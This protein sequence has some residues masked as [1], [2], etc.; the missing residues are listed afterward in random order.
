MRRIQGPSTRFTRANYIQMVR[1]EG[2][3]HRCDVG[4]TAF[5][6]CVRGRGGGR[7]RW[8][9]QCRRTSA[10]PQC[11]LS[12]IFPK[13]AIGEGL[14]ST[15]R[16]LQCWSWHASF[17]RHACRRRKAQPFLRRC[18]RCPYHVGHG[19]PLR[20]GCAPLDAL[21]NAELCVWCLRLR[22]PGRV[23]PATYGR[24]C[25]AAAPGELRA[26]S[27]RGIRD[28]RGW[29]ELRP[30]RP[31]RCCNVRRH[32]LLQGGQRRVGCVLRAGRGPGAHPGA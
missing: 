8:R 30:H 22:P 15:A 13:Y 16:G 1:V 7:L 4:A 9:R 6:K 31:R 24:L 27:A 12:P 28:F 21:P 11:C 29:R 19:K 17:D 10:P 20:P 18:H 14:E 23:R 32:A 5:E 2:G 26:A 25:A 3:R